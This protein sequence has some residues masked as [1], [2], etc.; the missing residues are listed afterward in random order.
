VT[1]QTSPRAVDIYVVGLGIKA[2][3]H[4]TR[5]AEDAMRRSTSI[6][7]V[8]AGF[9]VEE[10]LQ[11]LCPNTRCLL[12]HYQEM[13]DRRRT[14]RG[15]AAEVL[16]AALDDP[17]V[18]F[19]TYGHPGIYV[20]P[21]RLIT[22]GAAALGMAVQVMPGIS[23]L[24]AIITDLKLDPGPQGLQMYEATDVLARTRPLQPD[25]PC[26]LWQVG[27]LESALY[28]A[29]R[30]NPQRFLRLQRYLLRTYPEDHLVTMISSSTYQLLEPSMDTFPLSELAERVAQASQSGT[31][32][33]PAV[34]DRRVRD[35]ELLRDVYDPEHL[36]KITAPS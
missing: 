13:G 36:K 2:I 15:M 31:L 22:D 29:K 24:D 25:V 28:S 18:C 26:L 3:Q 23:A 27:A 14:Y 1:A 20:Y 33:I 19:A 4:I 21:T 9:G 34:G 10:Y 8:D 32:Y 16:D 17:P 5:E 12:D 6:L 30:G 11:T 7:Y 35:T